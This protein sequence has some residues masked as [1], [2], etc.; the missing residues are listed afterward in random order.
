MSAKELSEIAVVCTRFEATVLQPYFCC[1]IKLEQVHDDALQD[2]EVLR[3]I[4]DAYL[5]LILTEGRVDHPMM[6]I[7]DAPVRAHGM[8]DVRRVRWQAGYVVSVLCRDLVVDL[9]RA[10]LSSACRATG[11]AAASE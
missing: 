11:P 6:R 2:G 1:R 3:S 5:A 10:S 8:S 9:V 7:F 4:V